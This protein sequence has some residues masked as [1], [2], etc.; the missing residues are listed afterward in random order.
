MA[1]V[2]MQRAGGSRRPTASPST[3][4]AE[5]IVTSRP[6]GGSIEAAERTWRRSASWRLRSTPGVAENGGF[7]NTT[8]GRMSRSRSAMDSAL[9]AVTTDPGKSCVSSRARVWAYSLRYSLPVAEPP[10]AHS[11]ITASMPVPALGSSTTSPGRTAAACN[12]A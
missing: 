6:P 1:M 4:W 2:K 3:Q 12:A 7:I 5:V 11:A 8:V 10:S 9:K